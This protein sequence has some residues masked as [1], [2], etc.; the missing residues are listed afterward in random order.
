MMKKIECSRFFLRLLLLVNFLIAFLADVFDYN[1]YFQLFI[2]IY[3]F[4]LL[5]KHW[6]EPV[7][8]ECKE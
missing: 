2:V 7:K 8:D 5:I 6:K 1:E 4:T 3:T